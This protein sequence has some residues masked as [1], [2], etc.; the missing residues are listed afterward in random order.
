MQFLHHDPGSG[1][2]SAY[3]HVDGKRKP[4]ALINFGKRSAQCWEVVPISV[5]RNVIK[6]NFEWFC[7]FHVWKS[8]IIKHHKEALADVCFKTYF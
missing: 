6:N 3:E 1:L 8:Q 2:D 5:V 7:A 4:D